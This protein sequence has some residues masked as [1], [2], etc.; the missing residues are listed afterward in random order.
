LGCYGGMK[1]VHLNFH[2]GVVVELMEDYYARK[3]QNP[4]LDFDVVLWEHALWVKP[5]DYGLYAEMV[6]TTLSMFESRYRAILEG[7][8]YKQKILDNE[9]G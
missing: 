5:K 3:E 6:H 8:K 9:Q 4:E 1:K 7:G 2:P